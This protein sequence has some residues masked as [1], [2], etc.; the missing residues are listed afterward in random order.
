MINPESEIKR[1]KEDL[2]KVR[3]ELSRLNRDRGEYLLVSAHQMKS[4]LATIT[5]SIDT[6]LG[7]YAGR[8]NSK[9]LLIA[10]AI[11]RS[12]A[13]LQALIV[14]ILELEKFRSGKV[15]LEELDFVE[16]YAQSVDELREKLQEKN[17]DFQ[18]EVPYKVLITLGSRVGLRHSLYNLIENAVKYSRRD[19]VIKSL[20]RY[21]EGEQRIAYTLED[22]GIGI[23]EDALGRIFEEFF[24]APNARSYD[25]NGTGFGLA[26]VKQVVEGCGGTIAVSSRENEGTVFTVTFPLVAAREPSAAGEDA[27][28]K[29]IVV[30]GGV[31]AGP[32]AASRARRLDPAAKITVFEKENFLAY[33]GCALPFYISGQLKNQRDLFM[34]HANFESP[35]GYFRD[36]KG[37]EVRNLTEVTRIDR[38]KKRVHFREV[39][40]DRAFYEQ[41]DVLVLAAGS[42]SA[43]PEIEGAG[44]GNI[45][46]L[47]GIADS[48]RIKRAISN[49]MA[50]EIIVV[51]GGNIGVET[52][53]ALTVTGARVTIVEKER[54]ILP[55]LDH[56]MAA[57]VRKRL[58]RKGIRI[59]SGEEVR[60]F[61]GTGKV[62][63]VQLSRSKVPADLV[64]LAIGFKPNVELASAAGLR[65]GSTGAIAVN[66]YLETSDPS[67][68]AAGD[69]AE[70]VNAVSG[71]PCYLPLGSIANRQGRV[72]GTNAAGGRARF[73]PVTGTIIIRVFDYHFGKT[74]LNER[75]AREGGFDPVSCYVPEYDRDPFIPGAKLIHVKMTADR[76]TKKLLGVQIAGEGDV[77]KRIDVSAAVIASGGTLEEVA[78][79]DLGYAPAYSQALD[80]ILVASHV[81]QN[82]LEGRFEGINAVNAN[83]LIQLKRDCLCIDVRS[84]HEYEEERIPGMDLIPL[85]SIRR[86]IEEIPRD[87]SVV[88]VC[89]TGARSYQASLILRA[90]GYANVRILEGGLKMWPFQVARD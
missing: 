76:T 3:E 46:V 55:F 81:L 29:K 22:R 85:E 13:E 20:V 53:E 67:I 25:K 23:P 77:S 70:S 79:L 41:Y 35:S 56:E 11:K 69:C 40:T 34:K 80:N 61:S 38:E 59:I 58:E 15:E 21:D 89:D 31:A 71:K 64:I 86:R 73:G 9:Q 47:H 26:I 39:L 1:L 83:E 18:S 60:S 66:E 30:V 45:F 10:S 14:D 49:D 32:K 63:H 36:V 27:P 28:R 43:I 74:G 42:R 2:D 87:R 7:D 90:N 65:L 51:G 75:E 52:A 37:I 68:Y 82:K 17:I 33:A 24:R 62:E 44:L 48:E 57:L 72:A 8:L 19:G 50:K 54:E 16:V 88:L 6:L 4:P 84:P 12:S 78:S 5:F